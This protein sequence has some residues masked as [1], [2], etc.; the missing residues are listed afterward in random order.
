MT[1]Q[2]FEYIGDGI[3]LHGGDGNDVLWANKG[4]NW[5]FGDMGDDRLVGASEDDLIVGGAGD[6]R[7][8]GGGGDDVF[9]FCENWGKDMVEHLATGTVTLWFASGDE[10]K[11]DPETLTYSDGTNSVTVKGVTAEQIEL[12]FGDDGS[13]MFAWLSELDAFEAYASRKIFEE[14]ATGVLASPQ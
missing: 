3:S 13:E 11:W 7:M 14:A 10:S 2:R 1:S 12:K 8:H 4:E 5:L 9:T 6:D